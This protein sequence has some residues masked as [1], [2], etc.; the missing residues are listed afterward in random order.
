[1]HGI[2]MNCPPTSLE[3]H[4]FRCNLIMEYARSVEWWSVR[5]KRPLKGDLLQIGTRFTPPAFESEHR[6]HAAFNPP[7]ILFNNIVQVGASADLDSALPPVI[8]FVIHTHTAQSG[9]GGL[10]AV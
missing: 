7:V 6:T 2:K 3:R 5:L 9:M 4:Q 10:K 8:E 1:M